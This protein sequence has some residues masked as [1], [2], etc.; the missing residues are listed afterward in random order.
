MSESGDHSG[1][2]SPHNTGSL[3]SSVERANAL[4]RTLDTLNLNKLPPTASVS[5]HYQPPT[6]VAWLIGTWKGKGTAIQ[7][8]AIEV[9]YERLST[10]GIILGKGLFPTIKDF[11]YMEECS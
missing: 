9:V 8:L 11:E 10:R 6:A 2:H 7:H 3:A 4:H 5:S 1:N